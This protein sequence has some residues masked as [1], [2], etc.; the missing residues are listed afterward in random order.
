M[1]DSTRDEKD[2]K[3][4]KV[5]FILGPIEVILLALP[6]L[7]IPLLY[8]Q[9]KAYRESLISSLHL[10]QTRYLSDFYE[11]LI[12]GFH[13]LDFVLLALVSVL[14][15][16][17][18]FYFIVVVMC[19][20]K[21][22]KSIILK[23]KQKT[24]G[25]VGKTSPRCEE[26]AVKLESIL[27]FLSMLFFLFLFYVVAI[28]K[29]GK[30]GTEAGEKVLTSLE[31]KYSDSVEKQFYSK[32]GRLLAQG[33]ELLCSKKWCAIYYKNGT[34]VEVS[35]DNIGGIQRISSK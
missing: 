1:D 22:L 16:F 30:K 32:E 9:G 4:T 21:F 25:K 29:A 14:A 34:M 10:S 8:I 26:R 15:I 20:S 28:S 17:S 3:Q 12:Q 23:I 6:I 35:M 2:D 33:V 24:Q 31:E 11:T 13:T 18:I 27:I 5:G 7:F 19:D